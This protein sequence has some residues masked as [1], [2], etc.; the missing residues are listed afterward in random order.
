MWLWR[1]RLYSRFAVKPQP[2]TPETQLLDLLSVA[3]VAVRVLS[4]LPPAARLDARAACQRL[5]AICDA[6][7]STVRFAQPG[8]PGSP[9]RGLPFEQLPLLAERFPTATTVIIYTD[10]TP[11]RPP[12][13]LALTTL[14]QP[15]LG[16]GGS[17]VS[18]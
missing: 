3:D 11:N 7:L 4:S 14:K 5:R 12:G 16:G 10:T 6:R 9:C 15:Q 1:E 13:S 17:E 8:P 18:P 2:D